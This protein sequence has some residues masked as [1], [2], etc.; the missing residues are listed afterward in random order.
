MG[1]KVFC[2]DLY[3]P[4][5]IDVFD[6]T[7]WCTYTI[8]RMI[9]MQHGFEGNLKP[10]HDI[11]LLLDKRKNIYFSYSMYLKGTSWVKEIVVN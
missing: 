7:D 4:A 8:K 11:E 2:S 9:P 6:G 5:V 1:R 3:P 10:V